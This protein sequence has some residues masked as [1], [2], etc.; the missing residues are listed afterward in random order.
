MATKGKRRLAA[1]MFTDIVGYSKLMSED[2]GKGVSLRKRHKKIFEQCTKEND[3]KVIQYYGDGTLSMFESAVSAVE[4]AVS[5][6]KEF[7]MEPK[8]PLRIGIHLGD[9]HYD[10]TEV[11]GHGVNVAARIEPIC[12][13]G[14]IFISD[15]IYDE[16]KNHTG[17][18]A[19][20]LGIFQFKNIDREVGLY[21]IKE[22]G[23]LYP[24]P[25]ELAF[26]KEL[27]S[28]INVA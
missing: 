20:S 4:C 18:K 22:N 12:N 19:Q 21:A 3:G 25:K 24:D 5:M 16:I 6:Q 13:P 27:A 7:Q 8:V 26:I 2:E 14:G 10:D 23:I 28:K 9:I 17:L 11:F 1:I 15:K